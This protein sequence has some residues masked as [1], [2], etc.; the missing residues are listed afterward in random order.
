MKA[1]Q[2]CVGGKY[3]LLKDNKIVIC[4]ALGSCAFVHPEGEPDMQSCF[5]VSNNEE[6]EHA[7]DWSKAGCL[8]PEEQGYYKVRPK[9]I[10]PKPD[11]HFS[12]PFGTCP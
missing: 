7:D 12:G 10:P 6:V 1:K 5:G 2:M 8:T 11:L 3:R 4:Y 9:P